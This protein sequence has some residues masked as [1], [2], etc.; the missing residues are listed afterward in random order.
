M[1]G[2]DCNLPIDLSVPL[3]FT[4]WTFN[5]AKIYNLTRGR[6][7]WVLEKKMKNKKL[8]IEHF[9]GLGLGIRT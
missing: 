6:G 3:P 8:P 1:G 4:T 5:P 9:H 7:R 2:L